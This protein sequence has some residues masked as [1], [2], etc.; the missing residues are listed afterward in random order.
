MG[1]DNSTGIFE[2]KRNELYR[3]LE[4][5]VGIQSLLGAMTLLVWGFAVHY[6]DLQLIDSIWFRGLLIIS[7][8][9]IGILGLKRALGLKKIEWSISILSCV[10]Y[11]Y[12]SW[13]ML[14]SEVDSVWFYSTLLINFAVLSAV[15]SRSPA[16]FFAMNS[17]TASLIV[18]YQA[19]PAPDFFV[20]NG[21]L[22]LATAWGLSVASFEFRKHSFSLLTNL[23]GVQAVALSHLR[24]GVAVFDPQGRILAM[25]EEL[26]KILA[27]P[28]RQVLGKT[29]V[30]TKWQIFDEK[31]QPVGLD[32]LPS[33]VA[34]ITG[35]EQ[36]DKKLIL[37]NENSELLRVSVTAI[38]IINSEASSDESNAPEGSVMT[39]RD[40]T[41]DH[42][43]KELIRK[44]NETL[45]VA[46][47]LSALGEM[48]SGI[49][50]EIN[51]PLAI[52][53]GR[54][55]L[56]SQRITKLDIGDSSLKEKMLE[57]VG[58]LKGTAFRISKIVTS[59][60][61]LSRQSGRD[62]FQKVALKNIFD[63]VVEVSKQRINDKGIELRVQI[64]SEVSEVEFECHPGQVGQ[65]CLNLL[66]NAADAI[67]TFVNPWVELRASLEGE[68][69]L[70]SVTDCGN[71]IPEDLRELI[72]QP[73]FT[74]KEVGQGTGL[75]L[76]LVRT[77]A[78]S[79]HGQFEIDSKCT[80]TRFVMRYPLLQEKKAQT[81]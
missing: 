60:R 29:C 9:A 6:Y 4:F 25:N 14:F 17:L 20:L 24:D 51:N 19:K 81:L 8:L 43:Q 75:G 44:Q 46:S 10:T 21:Y 26:S 56:L 2:V 66:S 52:I 63:D 42:S 71:G 67:K 22:S 61:S 11:Y 23:A 69:L 80:N 58:K 33:A 70:I 38:P 62:E 48:A 34:Q 78:E 79:H 5:N 45:L 76:S 39:M 40:E 74:T 64:G 3:D 13:V 68:W 55:E 41:L 7:Y 30:G 12:V 27:L 57:D 77:I 36:I 73:F 28:A 53:T 72:M 50:H 37:K 31:G 32:L 59:M 1:K 54:T 65:A 47:R 15:V 49:A 18:L 16:Y 35:R